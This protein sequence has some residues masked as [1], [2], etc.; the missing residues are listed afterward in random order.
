MTLADLKRG[1]RV[2]IE[3]VDAAEATVRRLMV[4]G[5]VEGAEL[6][7]LG[8]SLGGDP[9]EL[10]IHGSA[11]SLRRADARRFRVSSTVRSGD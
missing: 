7:C 3:A 10:R 8:G 4:L 9:L 11:L 2:R 6:E 1:D 5:L